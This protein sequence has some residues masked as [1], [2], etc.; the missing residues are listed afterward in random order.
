MDIV[1]KKQVLLVLYKRAMKVGGVLLISA[2][3][4][5]S[6]TLA[7]HGRPPFPEWHRDN[8]FDVGMTT[9]CKIMHSRS[10]TAPI[11]EDVIRLMTF[12]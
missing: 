9:T 2:C 11:P 8:V 4:F 1:D 12:E 5:M 10:L 7:W 3:T 6:L